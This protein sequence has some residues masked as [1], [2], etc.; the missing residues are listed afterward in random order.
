MC[1]ALTMSSPLPVHMLQQVCRCGSFLCIVMCWY[2]WHRASS[3][4]CLLSLLLLLPLLSHQANLLHICCHYVSAILMAYQRQAPGNL[5]PALSS[6]STRP[7]SSR[8]SFRAHF[9]TEFSKGSRWHLAPLSWMK[10]RWKTKKRKERSKQL[11][12]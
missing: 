9:A 2:R 7:L 5:Y 11:K 12:K 3:A 4:I 6:S 1:S 10:A 8:P